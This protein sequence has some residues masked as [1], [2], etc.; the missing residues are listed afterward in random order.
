[1][2]RLIDWIAGLP[3]AVLILL[4]A[5]IMSLL[6]FAVYWFAFADSKAAAEEEATGAVLLEVPGAT[7]RDNDLSRVETYRREGARSA[8]SASEFWDQLEE[9]NGG[10]LIEEGDS[11]RAQNAARPVE[12]ELDP[13][14]YSEMEIYYIRQG[15]KTKAQVDAEHAARARE[16]AAQAAASAPQPVRPADSDSAYFARME[17]AFEMAQKYSTTPTESGSGSSG[18]E[19]PV[20]D[21]AVRTIEI[22]EPS[23]LP[24]EVF[25]GD[26]VITSLEGQ[27][28]GTI[29]TDGNVQI[30]P[31]RATFL[32]TERV[33]DGQR[34]IMR[35]KEE[36]RLSN[37]TVIPENTHVSGICRVGRRLCIE[38]NTVNYGD[39][40]YRTDMDV[41]DNDG[42]E[43][44]YCPVIEQNKGKK[45]AGKVAGQAMTGIASTA[46]TLF[47]GNPIVGR[48][49]SNS[50]NELSRT[51]LSNG[52]VAIDI[53]AGYDFYIFENVGQD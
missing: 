10:L 12:E 32:K 46:A 17:R 2:D 15:T 26:G 11:G 20:V 9:G 41:Y 37:G 7:I 3:K 21:S 25:S 22:P 31:T 35:L 6:G 13:S 34:V 53:V 43:G 1:M 51:T 16:A 27:T 14:I 40:I 30:R 29:Y 47:T 39:R 48:V 5:V 8:V 33:V 44:I 19:V 18:N 28:A 50:I 42:I 38:I 45:A 36:M 4:V 24:Q 49:A 23:T 52:S